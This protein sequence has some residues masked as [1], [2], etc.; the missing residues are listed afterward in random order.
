MEPLAPKLAVEEDKGKIEN[1]P[2]MEMLSAP[3]PMS[4]PAPAK[5]E[6]VKKEML[7]PE[8][9]RENPRL[10]SII[11]E[12]KNEESLAK[13]LEE[14]KR[15]L[16]RSLSPLSDEQLDE[17]HS[18]DEEAPAQLKSKVKKGIKKESE[19]DDSEEE[20]K[21]KSKEQDQKKMKKMKRMTQAYERHNKKAPEAP[22]AP[23]MAMPLSQAKGQEGKTY[24]QEVDTNVVSLNLNVLKDKTQ[25]A[26]GDPILCQKCKAMYNIYSKLNADPNT[27]E[28]H[29]PCEFC[30]NVNK[31]ALEPEEMPKADELTYV[32]ES[33][34]Q[35]MIK[36]GGG[37]DNSL[38]FCIDVSGSMC[39]SKPIDS[40]QAFKYDKVKKLQDLMKFSDG[41]YQY[42]EHE[43]RNQTYI[44][45]MQCL[46]A[47]IE[48]QLLDL[49]NGAPKRKVGVVIFNNDVTLIGYG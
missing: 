11:K 2:K 18:G 12:E 5:K 48:K 49:A 36:Q 46:Q 47:A 7:K 25:I 44:T 26:T 27:H 34:Q 42:T 38:I 24:E 23:M 31:I 21:S 22:S 6:E 19:S 29:W 14:P 16:S 40:K 13:F 33:A 30:D 10:L 43:T 9:P 41:S 28:Q 8:E 15:K 35:S 3:M 37:E 4:M 17:F 39:V 45:R 1:K 20:D 32:I